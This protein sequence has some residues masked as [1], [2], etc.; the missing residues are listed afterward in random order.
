MDALDILETSYINYIGE[1][2]SIEQ[3]KK[4][5]KKGWF[6]RLLLGEDK[7]KTL[8][9]PV[10]VLP[11]NTEHSLILDQ[12]NGTI[13]KTSKKGLEIPKMLRKKEA[14]FPS[15]VDV[16]LL[17]D[18][19]MLFTDSKLN[20]VYKIDKDLKKLSEL[21]NTLALAQP[22]GIAF[23]TLTQEIW[24]VETASHR[25][26][27]LDTSGNRIKTFGER[28]TGNAEFNYPTSICIGSNGNTYIVDALNYRVQVFDADGNFISMFGENGN[29]TGFLASPKGIATDS[30]GHL[31]IVDALFHSVQIFDARG[32]YLYHFGQ[33]G[34]GTEEFWMPTG[35]FIDKSNRIYIADSY[36]SRVQIFELNFTE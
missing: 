18:K 23:N 34:R 16:C 7:D 25:V 5:S 1:I 17:P 11:I 9:K 8:Q 28:G 30:F 10:T 27:I 33:Q 20:K 26:S 32:N 31:Y 29:G 19:S 22:T 15:L 21:N 35:I 3:Q 36:N 12:G 2:P 24:V 6:K 4:V 13:F 14:Y